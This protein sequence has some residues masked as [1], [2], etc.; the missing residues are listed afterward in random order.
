[1][2]TRQKNVKLQGTFIKK[3]TTDNEINVYNIY[4]KNG[5]RTFLTTSFYT[6]IRSTIKFNV[7]MKTKRET[8]VL[9]V[10]YLFMCLYNNTCGTEVVVQFRKLAL[11]KI[12]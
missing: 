6:S 11:A 1:M 9:N 5:F 10:L 12:F 2:L 7:T 4:T 8:I 3:N